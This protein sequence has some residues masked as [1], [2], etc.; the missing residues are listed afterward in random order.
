MTWD[1]PVGICLLFAGTSLIYALEILAMV[2]AIFHLRHRLRNSSVHIYMDNTAGPCAIAKADS[3]HFRIYTWIRYFWAIASEFSIDCWFEYVRSAFNIA[4]LPSR[5]V[6]LPCPVLASE[7]YISHQ[8]FFEQCDKFT[9][10]MN[11]VR[12]PAASTLPR[13]RV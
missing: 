8:T 7:S 1:V 4:D 9:A 13:A 12:H 10:D 11:L 6:P 3:D 5:E 2:L